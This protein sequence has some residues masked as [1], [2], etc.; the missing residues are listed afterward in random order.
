MANDGWTLG[1][2][3]VR[4]KL[5]KGKNK[6]IIRVNSKLTRGNRRRA[7]K[8]V[9]LVGWEKLAAFHEK[10]F[11]AT[12]TNGLLIVFRP[13]WARK[14]LHRCYES[15][16]AKQRL[17][18]P[19]SRHFGTILKR[20]FDNPPPSRPPESDAKALLCAH[21]AFFSAPLN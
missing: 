2:D 4:K 16:F 17:G 14:L 18:S 5:R 1:G 20:A 21:G 19:F 10:K 11:A 13:T 12:N 15:F 7:L 3:F 8:L 9:C 6:Q